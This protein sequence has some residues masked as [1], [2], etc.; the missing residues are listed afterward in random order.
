MKETTSDGVTYEKNADGT[1]TR[2][3]PEAQAPLDAK[4]FARQ[5]ERLKAKR[6]AIVS[7]RDALDSDIA[8]LDAD[9]A[10]LETVR[11]AKVNR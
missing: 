4:P 8:A 7:Q 10:K 11:D 9:I 6:D 1:V 2:T 3:V 5:I